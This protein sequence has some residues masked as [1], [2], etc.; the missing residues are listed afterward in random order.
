MTITLLSNE[1]RVEMRSMELQRVV[2]GE[3]F[4]TKGRNVA[5]VAGQLF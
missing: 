4:V 2:I 3:E 5:L 1:I